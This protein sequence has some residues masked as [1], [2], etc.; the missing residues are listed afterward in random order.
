MLQDVTCAVY[1]RSNHA[2]SFSTLAVH[3]ELLQM[4]WNLKYVTLEIKQLLK[5]L[6]FVMLATWHYYTSS[7]RKIWTIPDFCN[8]KQHFCTKLFVVAQYCHSKSGSS[9]IKG[10]WLTESNSSGKASAAYGAESSCSVNGP[11][12]TQPEHTI[13]YSTFACLTRFRKK[14]T[15]L[16]IGS[17]NIYLCYG[18]SHT[19]THTHTYIHTHTHTY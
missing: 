14:Q 15:L 5:Q 11:E 17:I 7:L 13:A 2:W 10:V 8:C 16:K 3:L 18:V 4:K 1:D 6:F 19:H 12:C 9:N